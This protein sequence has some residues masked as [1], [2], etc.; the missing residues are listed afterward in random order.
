MI[1]TITKTE[2]IKKEI[3]SRLKVLS[4]G[5]ALLSEPALAREYGVSRFTISR[6]LSELSSEGLVNRVQ[7]KGTFLAEKTKVTVKSQRIGFLTSGNVLYRPHAFYFSVLSSA[8]EELS[9]RD[10]SVILSNFDP[11]Y[12]SVGQTIEKILDNSLEG[13]LLVGRF[14]E[15]ILE[16]LNKEK[17]P[18]VLVDES[19]QN[20][21]V[22]Q[23]GIDNFDCGYRAARYLIEKGHRRIGFVSTS[24]V[25][26]GNFMER[27]EGYRKALSEMGMSFM[28]YVDD[29][30]VFGKGSLSVNKFL[31]LKNPPSAILAANDALAGDLMK[32]LKNAGLSLPEKIS[33]MGIDDDDLAEH[34]DPGLTTM[35]VPRIDMG[36]YAADALVSLIAGKYLEQKKIVLPTELVKRNSVMEVSNEKS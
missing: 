6:A 22:V 31:K 36:T 21:N 34:V 24:M 8:M 27:F 4:V 33:V 32:E 23:V 25:R 14:E 1:K 13:V 29:D 19:S 5:E 20:E 35:R 12:D 30:Y 10:Y 15:E 26:V 16:A 18:F 3:E 9:K 28:E 7:G 11:Q 17:V 2:Q